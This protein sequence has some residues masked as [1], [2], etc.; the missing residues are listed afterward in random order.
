MPDDNQGWQNPRPAPPSPPPPP[1]PE[2]TVRTMKSDLE[3]LKETGGL[4]PAPKPFTPP[5]LIRDFSRPAPPPPPPPKIA[6]ADFSAPKKIESPATAKET[7][8]VEEE[9][10]GGGG[11][12]KILSWAAILILAVLVAAGGYFYVFPLLFPPQIPPQPPKNFNQPA[13]VPVTGIP[14]P[15]PAPAPALL[16]HQS[17]LRFSDGAAPVQL[18]VVD[19]NSLK[20]AIQK[21]AGKSGAVGTLIEMIFSDAGGQVSASAAFSALLPEISSDTFKNLFEEDF[22]LALYRDENGAWPAYIFKLK[23]EASQVE[24]QTMV[25][26]LESSANLK[27]IFAADPGTPS[28][29]GFKNG[30]ADGTASRYLTYSKKGAALNIAWSGDKLII[31]TSYNGLKKIL[32]SL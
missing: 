13:E 10:T 31:S 21:E 29:G 4:T 8:F 15:A 2:I 16:P 24:A 19:L 25:K 1:P 12:K 28:V 20:T 18:A 26:D 11:L 5:E 3:S 27:N 30:Q 7:S 6:P 14:S 32:G 22:T 9:K 17:L 23:T